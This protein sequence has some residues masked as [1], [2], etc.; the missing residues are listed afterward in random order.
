[1]NCYKCRKPIITN[2][3]AIQCFYSNP[4]FQVKCISR[5]K[6]TDN[7]FWLCLNCRQ[8]IFPFINL[9]D[10]GLIGLTFNLNTECLCSTFISKS[11]LDHLPKLEITES[12]SKIPFLL[13]ANVDQN[14]PLNLNF[15]YYSVHDFHSDHEINN[16][17]S[18]DTFSML[19]CNTRSISANFDALNHSFSVIGLSETK[20]KVDKEILS[21]LSHFFLIRACPMLEGLDFILETISISFL[22][23]TCVLPMLLNSN[24]FGLKL[25]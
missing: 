6:N 2:S 5:K 17:I 22:E 4:N 7:D 3:E 20:L 16:F 14:I 19:H 24:H 8:D 15:K 10:S 23:M 12:S 1:M 11:K 18:S 25:R 9:T 21:N 13:N